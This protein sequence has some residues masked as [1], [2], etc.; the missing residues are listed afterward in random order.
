MK[1]HRMD[2]KTHATMQSA[3]HG[4]TQ[5]RSARRW[6]VALMLLAY[7]TAISACHWPYPDPREPVIEPTAEATQ[8]A[9]APDPTP[10]KE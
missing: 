5:E 9:S 1:R 10:Q 7:T 8:Q 3:E 4:A 6:P 2:S